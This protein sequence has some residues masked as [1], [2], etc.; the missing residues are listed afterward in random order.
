VTEKLIETWELIDLI[1]VDEMG[2]TGTDGLCMLAMLANKAKN[3]RIVMIGDSGQLPSVTPGNVL[4]QLA[5][6]LPSTVLDVV[7]RT[8]D[9][10]IGMACCDA[11]IGKIYNPKGRYDNYE[12]H[13]GSNSEVAI[14]LYN[15]N[16]KEFGSHETRLITFHTRDAWQINRRLAFTS[17][18]HPVVCDKNNYRLGIFNGQTGTLKGKRLIFKDNSIGISQILW[19]YAFGSTC[20]KAQGSQW[21]CVIVWIPSN[22]YISPQWLNTAESRAVKKLV[23]ALDTDVAS[24]EKCMRTNAKAA[25]RISL[26]AGFVQGSAKWVT[27]S[28]E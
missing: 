15:Q 14:N 10:H 2:M 17:Y 27:A 11:R 25:D 13:E 18:N 24:V 12:L 23:I 16:S 21:D 1:I 6:C 5:E 22:R 9:Y 28:G 4:S 26:L 8:D 20:H 7:Y 3:A 19:S